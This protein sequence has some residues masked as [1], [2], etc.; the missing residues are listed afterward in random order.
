M[1]TGGRQKEHAHGNSQANRQ[2]KKHL[3][4]IVIESVL[5]SEY[6]RK[7][8]T[9]LS[10]EAFHDCRVR[11][12][13]FTAMVLCAI[14]NGSV[15]TRHVAS[16]GCH[17]APASLTASSGLSECRQLFFARCAR[18]AAAASSWLTS[19]AASLL[20]GS[21]ISAA[22][23]CSTTLSP[24]NVHLSFFHHSAPTSSVTQ[25]GVTA[26]KE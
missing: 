15:A 11:A 3:R 23:I 20:G 5:F 10:S 18:Q 7:L 21:D 4:T 12:R 9:A 2:E 1:L 25:T 16:N 13:Q 19:S 8:L 24:L 14:L 17:F 6:V 26:K 22:K